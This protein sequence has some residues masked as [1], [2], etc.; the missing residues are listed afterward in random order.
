MNS[1]EDKGSSFFSTRFSL[2]R[3]PNETVD[4]LR[5]SD[6]SHVS[7]K[8]QSGF[9]GTPL[10]VFNQL[11]GVQK[12]NTTTE[13]PPHMEKHTV[14]FQFCGK[15]FSST[16]TN[17]KKA[18]QAA[19]LEA[20]KFMVSKVTD[21]PD[22]EKMTLE[23]IS[24]L[25]LSKGA[26]KKAQVVQ[27]APNL[28]TDS[29]SSASTLASS[30]T[31]VIDGPRYTC[32]VTKDGNNFTGRDSTTAAH[33]GKNDAMTESSETVKHELGTAGA[34]EEKPV[35][36]EAAKEE[37]TEAKTDHVAKNGTARLFATKREQIAAEKEKASHRKLNPLSKEVLFHETPLKEPEKDK[38]AVTLDRHKPLSETRGRE[39][40][41][42]AIRGSPRFGD[43]LE[44]KRS[45]EPIR[46]TMDYRDR[47]PSAPGER[48]APYPPMM[49]GTDSIGRGDV[50]P[51][52][53]FNGGYNGGGSEKRRDI[54]PI[55]GILDDR[56]GIPPYSPRG[57]SVHRPR[58]DGPMF[59]VR[60]PRF[61]GDVGDKRPATVPRRS[62]GSLMSGASLV[63]HE[64]K[65]VAPQKSWEQPA[66]RSPSWPTLPQMP[67]V[68]NSPQQSGQLWNHSG[69][70]YNNASTSYGVT[71][72]PDAATSLVGRERKV[73]A[74]RKPWG[75]SAARSPSLPTPQQGPPVTDSWNQSGHQYSGTSTTT[76]PRYQ[77]SAR[78]GQSFDPVSSWTKQQQS[79]DGG[80]YGGGPEERRDVVPIRG[81]LGDS[82]G[83]RGGSIDR[84]T[85]GGSMF[86]TTGRGP[87]RAGSDIRPVPAPWGSFGSS[88]VGASLVGQK[89]EPVA[90]LKSW[91][92]PTARLSSWPTP[93]PVPPV[94]NSPQ[95]PR[96]SYNLPGFKYGGVPTAYPQY[97][98]SSWNGKSGDSR[99]SWP[100]RQQ[101]YDGFGEA[102]AQQ[103]N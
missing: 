76:Y 68:A 21:G 13:G 90:P 33:G 88:A 38:D 61:I 59:Q 102:R 66:A 16:A 12:L 91:G 39:T 78:N 26:S 52:R 77:Q 8:K 35:E 43:R 53:G 74:P 63:G 55:K 15:E 11:F 93:K 75:Q 60:E 87:T 92:Q 65:S 98:Q 89:K 7:A 44:P 100:Q 79:S 103:G 80:Y 69:Y 96:Q 25:L 48:F 73:V 17:K 37:K 64:R 94:T 50:Y 31:G 6:E 30:N 71:V 27:V 20:L 83:E 2:K 58:R 45:F 81:I 95:Q 101:S 14:S 22:S 29:S 97:Q 49:T 10:S 24:K 85:G 51:D 56:L 34:K 18:S 41:S 86:Q 3:K 5:S 1:K 19:A 84:P 70:Q 32:L 54:A 42:R 46:S 9:N 4:Q 36:G 57:G 99:S 72:S 23:E 28:P 82:F 67:L 62:F 40:Q 47:M